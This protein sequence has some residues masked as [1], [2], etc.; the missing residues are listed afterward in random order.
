MRANTL[1]HGWI[2]Y[3]YQMFREQIYPDIFDFEWLKA[4]IS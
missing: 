2:N 3:P 1:K 4:N